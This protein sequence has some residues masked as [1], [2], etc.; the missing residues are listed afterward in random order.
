MCNQKCRIFLVWNLI[1]C[2]LITESPLLHAVNLIPAFPTDLDE[3]IL[4]PNGCVLT[5]PGH[6]KFSDSIEFNSTET[7]IAILIDA[8][9]VELDLTGYALY[10]N[11]SQN[12]VIGISISPNK[13]HI[14]IKN[15][16]LA[17]FSEC[18][19]NVSQGCYDI[20]IKDITIENANCTYAVAFN[21]MAGEVVHDCKLSRCMVSTVTAATIVNF[22]YCANIDIENSS[23]CCNMSDSKLDVLNLSNCKKCSLLQ[24]NILTSIATS[25]F[26]AIR[27]DDVQSLMLDGCLINDNSS[28][29]D[30]CHGIYF[31]DSI[32]SSIKNSQ[33][34][35]NESQSQSYYGIT[36][37]G[38]T[39]S[40]LVQH[41][42]VRSGKSNNR[43]CV[44]IYLKEGLNCIVA[45]CETMEN[46]STNSYGY[47]ILV[48][49][50][51]SPTI[52]KCS[53]F[54]NS[55]CGIYNDSDSSII[56]G[57]TAGSNGITNFDGLNP[58]YALSFY[59]R[60]TTNTQTVHEFDN[61]EF[62][63]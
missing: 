23:F 45:Q 42:V 26:V 36:I 1:F 50:A 47:G 52:K 49:N 37:T 29:S 60:G 48:E 20:D 14:T 31:S 15:G 27:A 39:S 8:D 24:S 41:C 22:S 51:S 18:G 25:T 57:C 61:V 35:G 3:R 9:F 6:Y 7:G 32:A 11:N 34:N 55:S 12:G 4:Y 33:I 5:A 17:Q 58:A 59:M 62:I 63:L 38:T 44:G 2:C 54:V 16:V 53:S 56:I 13:H 46:V 21:G 28:S 40:V 10:Q 30:D 19:I 43:E